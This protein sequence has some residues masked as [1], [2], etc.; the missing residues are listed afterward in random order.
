MQI[1]RACR[2]MAAFLFL[3]LPCDAAFGVDLTG[4]YQVE[5]KGADGV[6]YAGQVDLASYGKGLALTW[7]ADRGRPYE[8][9]GLQLGDAMGAVFWPKGETFDGLGIVLYRIDGGRL[10]GIWMP[11]GGSKAPLG[12]EDLLGP[13]TLEGRFEIT[14]GENPGGSSHY[15]GH[16]NIE[17]RDDIYY[18]HWYAPRDS[19]V[20]NGVRIGDV[21]VVG[22]A[23]GK[24]PGTVAYCARGR[25][26]DGIWS[27]AD[28]TRLG[29]EILR[30]RGTPV[31]DTPA[32]G[33]APDPR[34]LPTI[35]EGPLHE[36]ST[37]ATPG[38]V[39]AAAV[40]ANRLRQF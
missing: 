12:R 35:A 39:A 13:P 9:L 36:S 10:Q 17:R 11:Q 8:G 23:L 1:A 29:R 27:Y 2:R 18:F 37:R 24:A 31:V 14:L 38:E 20:G 19:Y 28:E 3:C 21:M 34:C 32:T 26:L 5:G 40:M 33:T 16:V 7:S 30:K 6:S 15:S 4:S 25:E 22:Y